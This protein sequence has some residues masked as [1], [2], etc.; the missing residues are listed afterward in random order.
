M[1]VLILTN[2][3]DHWVSKVAVVLVSIFDETIS[4]STRVFS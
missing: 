1:S 4:I 3:Y 2:Y